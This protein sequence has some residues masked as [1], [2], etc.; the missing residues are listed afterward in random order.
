MQATV[1]YRVADPAAGRRPARLLHRPVPGRW[2]GPAAGPDRHPARR[3]GP[4][5]RARPARPAAAGRGADRGIAAVREAV[6]AALAD[7]PRLADIGVQVVS[8]RVVAI[9][10]EPELERAL[11]TPTRE[12]VQARP[13]GPPTSGGPRPSSRSGR[14]PRTSCRTR[15]SWPAASS[16]WS[17]S[18]APTRAA[19]PSWTPPPQLVDGAGPGR[20]RPGCSPPPRRTKERAAAPRPRPAGVRARRRSP[21]R[22]AEAAK[23]GGLPGPAAGGA[24]GAGAARARRAPARD[25]PAHRHPRRASPACW[26]S[27]GPRRAR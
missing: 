24:A 21:R 4:A 6:S 8:A 1:T 2:P 27:A 9:R 10:P 7:D 16:S 19:R 23:L 5:A 26:R 25:R 3:A 13:T 15:S 14:S 12:A 11:Q 20:A 22:E 18:T 17:S